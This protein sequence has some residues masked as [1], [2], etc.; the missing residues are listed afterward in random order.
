MNYKTILMALAVL[1][2]ISAT[3]VTYLPPA[4]QIDMEAY[5]AGLGSFEI[6]SDT[7][8][9]INRD[10]EGFITL[11]RNGKA[12]KE[13][14]ASNIRDLYTYYGFSK[15][16]SGD[17]HV[18]FF[19][20]L[21]S[22]P[23]R[24]FGDYTVTIPAGFFK[25]TDS[26]VLNEEIVVNYTI[27]APEITTDPKSGSTVKSLSELT[28]EFHDVTS[29]MSGGNSNE[30]A[31]TFTPTGD[32]PEIETAL[33]SKSYTIDGDKVLFS[34]DTPFDAKGTFKMMIPES[35]FKAVSSTGIEGKNTP[36][37]ISIAVNPDVLTSTD[38][39]ISPS[40]GEYEG[41]T[42]EFYNSRDI[43]AFF[44][45]TLPDNVSINGYPIRARPL[46]VPVTDG[47]P[48]ID[49]PLF[50]FSAQSNVDENALYVYNSDIIQTTGDFGYLS[51]ET[52]TP[53]P[54]ECM[55]YIPAKLINFRDGTTNDDLY[56]EYTILPSSGLYNYSVTPEPEKR[57]ELP[58]DRITVDFPDAP[59]AQWVSKQ[60]ASIS[61][62][63]AEYLLTGEVV[64]SQSGGSSVIINIP[65]GITQPGIYT[66]HIPMN[67]LLIGGNPTGVKADLYLGVD[68]P[69][70]VSIKDVQEIRVDDNSL[71]TIDG[72]RKP[73]AVNPE[74][75][76]Y[77]R[78]GK[79][80]MVK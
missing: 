40:S 27:D 17:I 72:V 23:Y 2:F 36:M 42:S 74:R 34:F 80:I 59:S 62:G 64:E 71:Y 3:A 51:E 11:T 24:Y 76:V 79:K 55:L 21:Q 19:G 66:L 73:E 14:P 16:D 31:Y 30:F 9:S 70:T 29:V 54:G 20:K 46:L 45:I 47:V 78:A 32:G 63:V 10:A 75:G 58:V 67:T 38:F 57:V 25:Y 50:T 52:L 35:T 15:T 68:K 43:Y 60:Y 1:P 33:T 5:P 13:I 44:K 65:N 41:F 22:C 61:D 37:A 39:T 4:G 7:P 6:T 12:V 69:G 28:L 49:N 77:V 8:L 56:F 53:A 48:D 26:G 18:T